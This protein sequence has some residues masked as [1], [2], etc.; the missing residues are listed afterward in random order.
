MLH[1]LSYS[2][3]DEELI[4]LC[5]TNHANE[6]V[7]TTNLNGNPFE[8]RKA[9]LSRI[10]QDTKNYYVE[11]SGCYNPT[12][13]A[14]YFDIAALINYFVRDFDYYSGKSEFVPSCIYSY[15]ENAIL[16]DL[17]LSYKLLDLDIK[18]NISKETL[19]DAQEMFETEDSYIGY[20]LGS[21][22]ANG[23]EIMITNIIPSNEAKSLLEI[24]F[25]NSN[26]IIDY[27]GDFIYSDPE[28]DSYP[29]D[30][31][32]TIISK[33]IDP[34]INI[35]NPVLAIKHKDSSITFMLYINGTLIPFNKE[36]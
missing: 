36:S 19:L 7:C 3:R 24:A 11:G 2:I 35:N 31:L 34:E 27:I 29:N 10:A 6:L 9:Y 20:L 4:S 8:L 30:S 18:L 33:A 13:L 25:L 21:Y 1:F 17:V 28:S 26:G 15:K 5:I 23:K 16:K 14:K 12:F 32:E 22:S